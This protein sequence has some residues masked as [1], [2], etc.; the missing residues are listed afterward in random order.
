[1]R[2][3]TVEVM[4][5]PGSVVVE[6]RVYYRR[7]YH[8]PQDY[9]YIYYLHVSAKTGQAAPLPCPDYPEDVEV[10]VELSASLDQ[11]GDVVYHGW[12]GAGC[13]RNSQ[14]RAFAVDLRWVGERRRNDP[15][16]KVTVTFK[17]FAMV[18]GKRTPIK[19]TTRCLRA[20]GPNVS[21]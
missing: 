12:S 20:E 9:G 15:E 1:M 16:A 10:K 13:I 8:G 19:Q 2:W 18:H 6:D 4:A 5:H 3:K 21:C 14:S 7:V 17:L 11:S